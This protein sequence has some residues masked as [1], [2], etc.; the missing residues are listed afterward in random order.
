MQKYL[1]ILTTF[2]PTNCLLALPKY[3]VWKSFHKVF[4]QG[5]RHINS[6]RTHSVRKKH[7]NLVFKYHESNFFF[8]SVC[9]VGFVALKYGSFCDDWRYLVWFWRL[10]TFGLFNVV[11]VYPGASADLDF[12]F[13]WKESSKIPKI[14]QLKIQVVYLISQTYRSMALVKVSSKWNL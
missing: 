2:L 3:G 14:F 7:S 13:T 12:S 5:Q 11:K 6:S 10:V 8:F 9:R 1:L 4:S